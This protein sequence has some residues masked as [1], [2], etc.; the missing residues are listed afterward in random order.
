A[1][2]FG[3]LD[4]H[5]RYVVAARFAYLETT[6]AFG[7]VLRAAFMSRGLPE[8]LYVDN[9]SPFASQ[10]LERTLAVL[11]V[12]LIHSRPGRPQGRGKV[13]RLFRTIREGFLQEAARRRCADLAELQR[14]L[15]AWLS[16][17]YHRR[18]HSETG[19][20]PLARYRAFEPRYA[21]PERLR[22]AF[23]WRAERT[24]SATALVS[25][26]GN[27]Y[28]VDPA[29]VGARVELAYD[30]QDLTRIEVRHRGR[31]RGLA[32]PH[33]ITRHVH[34]A[35]E[36]PTGAEPA[37]ATGIDYLDLVERAEQA[38][39]RRRISYRAL[40]EDADAGAGGSR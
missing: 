17:V 30:P 21:E 38:E 28:E 11:G 24:V 27:R 34:Q 6:L 25:L 31:A 4:D 23:L 1:L 3:I 10:A 32:V 35:A 9:G 36:D 20:S 26:A 15:S 7:Q 16:Q 22:E 13:E 19:E 33:R 12:R 8:R 29:L 14:L 18:V 2:L 37:P 5:S 39:L 40:G